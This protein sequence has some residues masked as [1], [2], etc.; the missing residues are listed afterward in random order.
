MPISETAA[1]ITEVLYGGENT[2]N[3]L[4]HV[5][6]RAMKSWDACGDS[7]SPSVCMGFEPIKKA[8]LDLTKRQ[9]KIRFI[10]E[11]N[12]SNL[13][14]CKELMKISELRHLDGVKGNFGICDKE[15]YLA[16]PTI[17]ETQPAPQLI[18]SN[19]KEFIEQQQYIFDSFWSKSIPSEQKIREIEEGVILGSTEVVLVPLRMQ[20]LFI[21]LVKSAKQEMLLILPTTNAFLREYKL[22]IIQLLKQ[23]S[24]SERNI[25][26]RIL[27]PTN[28]A[29][30]EILKNI[31]LTTTIDEQKKENENFVIQRID[32]ATEIAVSTVT[33]AVAD[34]QISLVI[35]KTDDT[36]ENFI[37]AVGLATY[38]TSKPTVSS[39]VSIF[40]NLWAQTELYRQ[41]KESNQQI[42]LANEQLKIHD[43]MQKQF[44]NVAAHELKTP[45]QG[46]LG[47]SD[48]LKRYPEK[49]D[50]ITEA[51]C[52]NATRLQRLINDILD[53]TKI[54]S[55]NFRL[56]K[57]QLNLNSLISSAV[58]DHGGKVNE[59]SKSIVKILLS[60]EQETNNNNKNPIFVEADK[61]RLT[62]VISNLL[63]NAVKFTQKGHITI[64]TERTGSDA[65]VRVKDTGS[66]IDPDIYP[67]LFSKF[68]SKSYQGTGLG[69]FISK[70]IVEAHG[71]KIW[72]ENNKNENGVTFIFT[73]PLK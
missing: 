73:L 47:F 53:I 14:Y 25:N 7:I 18:Y 10:T 40:E 33:I 57:E 55:Q 69:L 1:G 13:S 9:I 8:Y 2:A 34:R 27:T 65:I 21:D 42:A 71:G 43:R 39:Y 59:V 60:F 30:E 19:I 22:G 51:I 72:V 58:Q 70:S 46:I 20:E 15:E 3:R 62:Q 32:L 6:S 44:I 28:D 45:T 11:I 66:G 64:S 41:L 26:V 29:I 36:K 61:F 16:A 12:R 56:N 5:F 35:E 48:L 49:R 38:S 52:R 50:E 4:L 37:D 68:A 54:E 17:T 31:T 67:R 24:V 63:S 23:E